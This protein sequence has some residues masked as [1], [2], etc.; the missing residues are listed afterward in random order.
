MTL[1]KL[2]VIFALVLGVAFGQP[3]TVRVNNWEFRALVWPGEV[4]GGK[5]V[6]GIGL[7][8]GTCNHAGT[9]CAV[10]VGFTDSTMAYYRVFSDGAKKPQLLFTDQ[11]YSPNETES[12]DDAGNIVFW[13]PVP[14]TGYYLIN[15]LGQIKP[16]A[17]IGQKV[18]GVYMDYLSVGQIGSDGSITVQALESRGIGDEVVAEYREGG[19]HIVS[20]TNDGELTLFPEAH[21][22]TSRRRLFG[23]VTILTPD[24]TT[25]G[26][27]FLDLDTK[28]ITRLSED[29]ALIDGAKFGPGS[30]YG[31]SANAVGAVTLGML[32]PESDP[33][34]PCLVRTNAGA[35]ISACYDIITTD[36]KTVW[37]RL[38]PESK[39]ISGNAPSLSMDS[40]GNVAYSSVGSKD[41]L[42][43]D[44][45][46]GGLSIARNIWYLP[47]GGS[48]PEKVLQNRD[49]LFVPEGFK[50]PTRVDG[51]WLSDQNEVFFRFSIPGWKSWLLVGT[52]LNPFIFKGGVV[53]AAS[54]GVTA[55]GSWTSIF[56]SNL[57]GVTTADTFDLKK[58]GFKTSL[59][60]VRVF[61]SG[62]ATPLGFISPGQ[63]NF[64]MPLET[65]TDTPVSVQVIRDGFSSNPVWISTIPTAPAVFQCGQAPCVTDAFTGVKVTAENPAVAGHHRPAIHSAHRRCRGSQLL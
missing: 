8:W 36:W 16:I 51:L 47:A 13:S 27:G 35:I 33:N 37:R 59:N 14:Q 50:L 6:S 44:I 49:Q 7:V 26:L 41:F 30:F 38:L 40:L 18:D 60:G 19:L 48:K 29:G 4:L 42:P 45:T 10:W 3:P 24:T 63:I 52:R 58:G 43:K 55:P 32:N 22:M 65:P 11:Q 54:Y 39:R 62:Q 56:G 28:F 64:Q 57:S 2:L 53:N 15:T 23:A 1:S 21:G 20:K 9:Q 17:L 25:Y 31:S 34:A 61:V 5:T 12:M 46:V